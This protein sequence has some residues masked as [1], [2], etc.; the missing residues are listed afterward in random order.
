VVASAVALDSEDEAAALWVLDRKIDE[1]PSYS[2]LRNDLETLLPES[3]FDQFFKLGIRFSS[4]RESGFEPP[5]LGVF[6]VRFQHVNASLRLL[7]R[8]DVVRS[9]RS[10]DLD[11]MLGAAE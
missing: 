2:N 11:A 10:E 3:I 1:V 5:R 7:V 4:A 8:P 9:H 6:E